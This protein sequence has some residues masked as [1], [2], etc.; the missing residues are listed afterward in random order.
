MCAAKGIA[1]RMI[2][3]HTVN[4]Y[5]TVYLYFF[6][7]GNQTGTCSTPHLPVNR[8][9]E[10]VEDHYASLRFHPTFIN[11][12]QAN[13]AAAI[14]EEKAAARL[15]RDQLIAELKT[16]DSQEENLLD[17]AA[18]GDLPKSKIKARLH[19]IEHRRRHLTER[20]SHTT[21]ELSEA[22][23][24]VEIAL[25][26]L[27]DPQTLYL[28]ANEEV[29]RMLNQAIFHAL[30][31]QDDKIS[32]HRLTEPFASL[33]AL[34]DARRDA[35]HHGRPLQLRPPATQQPRAP[36]PHR[37]EMPAGPFLR[38]SGLLSLWTPY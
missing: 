4:R 21:G 28:R 8:L 34:H 2:I 24:L 29:H 6:C 1:Q 3:Q 23:H 7:R 16:M 26:L 20:L 36:A 30:Y 35:P 22:A 27:Q 5:G 25:T 9:E 14:D 38:R 32:S 31:I 13:L 19:D 33:H 12:V 18:D 10:A 37:A 17:L 15:L 11:Q